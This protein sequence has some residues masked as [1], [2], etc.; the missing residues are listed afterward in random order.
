MA[1]SLKRSA[2][3]KIST[4]TDDHE[5]SM[6]KSEWERIRRIVYNLQ[7]PSKFLSNISFFFLGVFVSGGLTIIPLWGNK[8]ISPWI[9]TTLVIGSIA[10]LIIGLVC[11][12]M[13]RS[14]IE[15][16]NTSINY[17]KDE[18]KEHE[19]RYPIFSKE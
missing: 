14:N 1:T 8:E 2:E 13:D 17:L 5:F 16:K 4:P 18:M 6:R 10:S 15:T 19:N 7:E 9:M 11:F 12:K 3:V